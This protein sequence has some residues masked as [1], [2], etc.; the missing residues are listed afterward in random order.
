MSQGTTGSPKAA[1]LSHYNVVNNS[2][3]LGRRL[4]TNVKVSFY[5]S[6][7]ELSKLCSDRRIIRLIS[8]VVYYIVGNIF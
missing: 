2:M 7:N 6:L 3:M 8:D 5:I 4:E 1:V